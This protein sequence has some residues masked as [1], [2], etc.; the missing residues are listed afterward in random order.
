MRRKA[1]LELA[2]RH[3]DAKVDD[4]V[5]STVK[6][7]AR[8]LGTTATSLNERSAKIRKTVNDSTNKV[9]SKDKIAEKGL[10]VSKGK[11][12]ELTANS[13]KL[14]LQGATAA[15]QAQI[16]MIKEI[17]DLMDA[18]KDGLLSVGDVRAYFRAIGRNASDLV[19]RKWIRE[20]DID[21][22]GAVS[23]AEFVGSYS[24]QLDPSSKFGPKTCSR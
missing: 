14:F 24:H 4:T 1:D 17:F 13:L 9:S 8:V 7:A 20:R 3:F 5:S 23:L 18:D 16:S 11:G 19:T 2:L 10:Q 6:D 21:Q 12:G 22:D 15:Q